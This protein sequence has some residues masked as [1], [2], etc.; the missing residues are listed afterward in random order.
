L[1]GHSERRHYYS[2]SAEMVTRKAVS[3][4]EHGLIPVICV[5]ETLTERENGEA[6][7]VLYNDV[8]ASLS[9]M[10]LNL[11]LII[12]YEPVWAIGT[13]KTATPE[14]AETACAYIRGVVRELWG[15]AAEQI[16]ILYGGSVKPSNIGELMSCPD[17][18]GVLVGGAS[19]DLE[20]FMDIIHY[21]K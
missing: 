15:D 10:K 2:E 14:D 7:E 1:C 3:A 8:Y 9:G 5:G 17:I 19:L 16:R 13:G 12:A 6:L 11:S 4:V 18:D 20:K 21:R